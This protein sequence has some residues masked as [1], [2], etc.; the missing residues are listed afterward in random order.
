VVVDES[1]PLLEHCLVAGAF[2][3][4]ALLIWLGSS[5]ILASANSKSTRRLSRVVLRVQK[6]VLFGHM[7]FGRPFDSELRNTM[8]RGI[9]IVRAM[10]LVFALLV[11]YSVVAKISRVL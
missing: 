7:L 11:V 8:R 4:I 9:Y 5:V 1:T 10:L 2:L 3:L 6:K